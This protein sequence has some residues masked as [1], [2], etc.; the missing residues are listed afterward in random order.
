MAD[1]IERF[2]IFRPRVWS[3]HIRGLSTEKDTLEFAAGLMRENPGR[4]MLVYGLVAV[5]RSDAPIVVVRPAAPSADAPVP[6][7]AAE[8]EPV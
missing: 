6:Q 2:I 3:G 4:E 5:V 8:Q 7:A 1:D